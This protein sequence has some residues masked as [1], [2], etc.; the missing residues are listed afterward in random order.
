[1]LFV[2]NS[3]I[4]KKKIHFF[5][6]LESYMFVLLYGMVFLYNTIGEFDLFIVI[7]KFTNYG[8]NYKNLPTIHRVT[9]WN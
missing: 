8:T 4:I 6:T 9:E 2:H 7:A 3:K 1:M 5:G